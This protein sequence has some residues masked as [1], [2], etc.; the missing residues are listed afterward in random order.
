MEVK[1]SKE[2]IVATAFELFITEGY[3]VGINRIVEKAGVSRGALYHYFSSKEDLFEEVVKTYFF[4]DFEQ[5]PDIV[6][7]PGSFQTKVQQI[8][9]VPLSPFYVIDQYSNRHTGDGYLTIISAIRQNTH[10]MQL[11]EE[12]NRWWIE[13]LK[14]VAKQGLAEGQLSSRRTVAG[15]VDAIRLVVDGALLDAY[16]TSLEEAKDKLQRCVSF[17]LSCA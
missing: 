16:N 5:L 6:S 12:Y 17:I 9:D 4:Q 2:N 1:R 11:Q 10:L 14:A 3:R 8:M 13:S 15:L 7:G